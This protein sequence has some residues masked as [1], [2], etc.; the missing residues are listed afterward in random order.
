MTKD[1]DE[2]IRKNLATLFRFTEQLHRIKKVPKK[3]A[4]NIFGRTLPSLIETDYFRLEK[5]VI[6]LGANAPTE[7]DARRLRL[8]MNHFLIMDIIWDAWDFEKSGKVNKRKEIVKN[9]SFLLV[10]GG[11]ISI[12][13]DR[14][15]IVSISNKLAERGLLVKLS[16]GRRN[17][18]RFSPWFRKYF[19]A[20]LEKIQT[21][22]QRTL[23]SYNN[24]K[25]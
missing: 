12:S 10:P 18:Y 24:D 25:N 15:R 7:Q 8:L 16:D 6:L 4:I 21:A 19:P 14:N 22:E 13:V 2:E 20:L 1:L 3:D 5:D 17:V 23:E 11:I 9:F